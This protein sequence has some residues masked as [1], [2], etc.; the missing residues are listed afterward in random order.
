MIWYIIPQKRSNLSWQNYS[1]EF[2][3]NIQC[4]FVLKAFTGEEAETTLNPMSVGFIS[5]NWKYHLLPLGNT[6]RCIRSLNS[7]HIPY[8]ETNPLYRKHFNSHR[9]QEHRERGK[10]IKLQHGGQTRGTY[11]RSCWYAI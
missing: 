6:V 7:S 8:V 11:I 1:T 5:R 4:S 10:E 9:C 2:Q 3:L